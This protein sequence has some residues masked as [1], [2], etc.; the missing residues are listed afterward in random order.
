MRL[1]AVFLAVSLI[2]IFPARAH[3]GDSPEQ[4]AFRYGDPVNGVNHPGAQTSIQ[5]FNKDGLT[6]VC[7]FVNKKV[8]M[9]S[10]SRNDRA[11]LP[12]EIEAIL[13]TNGRHINWVPGAGFGPGTYKRADGV[14]ATVTKTEVDIQSPK[15]TAAVAKDQ[16]AAKAKAAKAAQ[17]AAA[18]N[19]P[20]PNYTPIFNTNAAS[21]VEP[22]AET[23]ATPA[24]TAL[25]TT[26]SKT[27]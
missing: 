16:A 10:I 26:A 8:E 22:Q 1:V 20:D 3:L 9:Y 21:Y 18:A 7:G 17:A 5:V 23:K 12:P 13:R 24:K 2:A 27:P 6:I 14:T 25:P 11:F 4:A 19:T 15:W